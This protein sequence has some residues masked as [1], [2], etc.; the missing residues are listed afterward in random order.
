MTRNKEI[1]RVAI[2]GIIGNIVLLVSK[3]SVGFLTRSQTMIADGL[4]SAGD[5]FASIMTYI[6]N[7][8][9]AQPGDEDH[10][11]GHGKAE[12]IFSM[13]ISFS[14]LLV[15]FAIFRSSLNT[16]S[17]GSNFTYSPYLIVVAIGTIIVKICLFIYAS[18]V[19][20]TYN[21]LLAI[22]NAED[23]RNDVFITSLT[24]ISIF[25]GFF[26]IYLVDVV[27]GIV[28]AFWI[29]F[30][31]FQIFSSA[32][33][34]LMDTNIDPALMNEF[35]DLVEDVEGVDHIDA[36]TAKPVGLN[37]L[38]IVKISVDANMTVYD[39]HKVAHRVRKILEQIDHV[40]EVIVHINAAQYHPERMER[41]PSDNEQSK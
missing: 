41:H 23:H 21:S 33:S 27:G 34:V 30:T 8:I 1:Q 36:I 18:R 35:S 7:H 20:K 22:A 40:E 3:L 9:S 2:F 16:L 13:I 37:F 39:G 29:A 4:N 17:N 15:A 32:Y 28:I 6:G 38:L 5:V 10:P 25:A 12:Y 19:G 24:L 26:G 31:G 14:L 11:Y